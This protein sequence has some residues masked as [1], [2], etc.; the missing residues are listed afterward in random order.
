MTHLPSPRL[1]CL[2]LAAILLAGC[3]QA[4]A[5]PPSASVQGVTRSSFQLPSGSGCAGEVGRFHAVIDNDVQ[6]GHL[7]K[8][9]YDRMVAEVDRASAAC[10][11]GRDAE[12]TSLLRSTK[13]RFGYP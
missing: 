5:P 10:A 13:S 4:A 6:I 1:A 11:A 9:V 2:G 7:N 3:N 12:A 8:S